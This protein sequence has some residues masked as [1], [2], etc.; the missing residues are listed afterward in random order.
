MVGLYRRGRLTD[1]DLD[2]QMD[3]IGKEETAL[4]AQIGELGGKIAGADSIAVNI[5]SAQALLSKLRRRLEEPVSWELKRRLIEVLVAGVRVD[6]V[7]ERGVKQ[8]RITVTYRF[9]DPGQGMPVTMPQSYAAGSVIRIPSD[10]QTFGRPHP[11]APSG[12]EH[13]PEGRRRTDWR[14][15]DIGL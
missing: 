6:T 14:R 4:E 8:S 11:Q 9:T 1:A 5:S 2:A 7:E 3:E 13:A 15:Q 10:P 12:V